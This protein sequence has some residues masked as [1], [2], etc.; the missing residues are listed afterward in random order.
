[1]CPQ[2]TK[3]D[4]MNAIQNMT[5]HNVC[6]Y[7]DE[8]NRIWFYICLNCGVTG[9]PH[10]SCS[11][12]I[13]NCEFNTEKSSVVETANNFNKEVKEYYEKNYLNIK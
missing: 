7:K 5:S 4:I 8:V 6:V 11:Y 12:T 10:I 1:M 2:I 13:G 9:E 3:I